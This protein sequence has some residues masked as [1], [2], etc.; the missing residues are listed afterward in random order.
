LFF[1][2]KHG[3][4]AERGRT[5]YGLVV[6]SMTTILVFGVLAFS[7]IP[8]LRA[9]GMTAALGSLTC[10]LFAAFLAEDNLHAA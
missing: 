5:V 2:Q 1:N 7:K 6:C 4:P 8:V 10:L 3:N 9:I